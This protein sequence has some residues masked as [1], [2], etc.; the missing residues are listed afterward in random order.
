MGA[1]G[2]VARLVDSWSGVISHDIAPTAISLDVMGVQDGGLY[3]NKFIH[4]MCD[5]DKKSKPKLPYNGV[6]SNSTNPRH[7]FSSKLAIQSRYLFNRPD[8]TQGP[9]VEANHVGHQSWWTR[10]MSRGI[11][12][13]PSCIHS[14]AQAIADTDFQKQTIDQLHTN[15]DW[16]GIDQR[17]RPW[18]CDQENA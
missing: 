6:I 7:S 1:C 5:E 10:F 3:L 2:L 13:E 11:S 4:M 15:V 17:K 16:I 8:Q 9:H 18:R 12:V 14:S